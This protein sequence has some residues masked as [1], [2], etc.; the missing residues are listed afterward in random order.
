MVRS[1]W[2]MSCLLAA[3]FVARRIDMRREGWRRLAPPPG[4]SGGVDCDLLD[5]PV[6]L[7]RFWTR[8]S[9]DAF[10]EAPLGFVSLDPFKGDLPL[11]RAVVA[12]ADELGVVA[13]L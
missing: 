7:F 6:R 3:P 11:E 10:F 12:L 9:Q 13:A 1:I 2:L 5:G 8:P 4:V